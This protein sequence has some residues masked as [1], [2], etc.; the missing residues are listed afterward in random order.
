MTNTAIYVDHISK[1]YLVGSANQRHD[2]L[3]DLLVDLAKWRPFRGDENRNESNRLW[4]L[5]DISFEVKR[6]EVLGIIGRNGAGKSTL[7]KILSRITEPTEGRAVINGRVGSLLEV[8]TGFHPELTGREN[9]YL[10]GSL[11]GMYRNEID[12]KFDEIVAFAEI[13]KFLETPVKRYSSGM[14]VRLAFAVAAHLEPEILFIDEVLAVGDLKFQKKCLGKMGEIANLGRTIL[15][16]SH[17]MNAVQRICSKSLLLDQGQIVSFGQTAKVVSD[18]YSQVASVAPV[19]QWI[20]LTTLPREG[21]G[22]ARFTKVYLSS[23]ESQFAYKPFPGGPLEIILDI[24]SIGTYSVSALAV[25][26]WDDLGTMLINLDTLSLGKVI[27]L[28]PGTNFVVFKIE[29]L[30]LNA[31]VYTFAF[32]LSDYPAEVYDSIK[33]CLN[34]EVIDQNAGNLGIPTEGTVICDF[35]V[36]QFRSNFHLHP[37]RSAMGP[38]KTLS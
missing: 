9:V 15:F 23:N 3:R 14:Y 6:G 21:T 25:S 30:N 11:L 8:G 19:K 10:N 34:I 18:Y 22:K 4:A 32:W 24:F 17:N 26:L 37:S 5:K 13:E 31:G 38:P 28:V 33:Y 36:H 12:R 1:M 20:D 2:T 35:V 29:K 27:N 16:V 7:L